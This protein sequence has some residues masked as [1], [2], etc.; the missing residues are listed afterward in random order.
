M[1]GIMKE[2]KAVAATRGIEIEEPTAMVDRAGAEMR[3]SMQKD[4]AA[5]RPLELDHIAGPILRGGREHGVAT[6]ATQKL[7]E[8]V[9]ARYP[10]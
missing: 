8:M 10:A 4:A 6:P 9:R 5:G 7:V 2:V 1:V 3:S